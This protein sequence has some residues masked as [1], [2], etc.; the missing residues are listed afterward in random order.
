MKSTMQRKRDG[1]ATRDRGRRDGRG[2]R[3]DPKDRDRGTDRRP[4]V[5]RNEA[6]RHRTDGLSKDGH[7]TEHPAVETPCA[8]TA[9][10]D[11]Q[12]GLVADNVGLV[13]VHLRRY[14]RPFGGPQRDREWEDLFQE[15]CLGLIR[16][17]T[18]YSASRG[19]PFAAYALPRIHNAVSRAL[20]ERFATVKIPVKRRRR[21]VGDRHSPD[22]PSPIGDDASSASTRGAVDQSATSIAPGDCGHGWRKR[23]HG[24]T[25]NADSRPS[26]RDGPSEAVGCRLSEETTGHAGPKV[27]S[28]SDEHIR[29]LVA[30]GRPDR[31]SGDG[32]TIGFRLRGKY[33]RAAWAAGAVIS[34]ATSRRGDRDKL[35]RVLLEERLLIPDDRE[36]TALRQIARETKSSYARVAQCDKQIAEETR[37]RLESDPEF[38]ALRQYA[39]SDE[40]GTEQRITT[41]M[42]SDLVDVAAKEMA[43]RFRRGTPDQQSDMIDR[44]LQESGA[45]AERLISDQVRRLPPERRERLLQATEMAMT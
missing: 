7:G 35:V 41:E 20:H 22:A 33:E 9:M 17:A 30:R 5:A 40:A 19:I 27:R 3:K 34:S 31:D 12:R 25:G 26:D 1:V 24:G 21:A 29:G 10:T 44:L 23:R 43:N 42:E 28:M 45:D 6:D 2:L 16:A 36:R 15:G 14:V 39:R 11:E 38:I 32:E 13:R 4:D 18:T 37:R 8:A